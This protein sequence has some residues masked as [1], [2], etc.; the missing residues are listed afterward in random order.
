[1]WSTSKSATILS[2]APRS[3]EIAGIALALAAAVAFAL[4]NTSASVAYHSGSNPLTVAAIRF[5][6]PTAALI[7]W[8][9]M[10]GVRM[11]LQGRD[12]WI[13]AMLGAVTAVYTW[14]LL[15]A[16]GAIPLSLAIL[17]FY[18]FPLIAT[19]ILAACGWERFGWPT[20]AAIVLAFAGLALALD[21]R[22]VRFN[23]EGV[24]LAAGAALGL[25]LVIAVSS[26]VFR[27]GDSRP[28]TLYMAATA[29]MV[30]IVLCAMRGGFVL[31]QTGLGWLGFVGTSVFYAFAMIAFFIAISMIGPVRVSLLS[32]AEPVVA[33]GLSVTLLG[34][35]LAPIQIAGVVLVITALVGATLWRRT[36]ATKG[37]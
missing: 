8:L 31:P 28:V 7:V 5:L 17:V 37:G 15:S 2:S 33:A 11:S 32:Y 14:A 19:I 34:D 4:S 21:P 36:P 1:M 35:K 22:G 3:R 10:R 26:R 27:A 18:L 24:A 13:A 20:V 23:F 16:I 12:G 30:L 9:R 29:A 25:G 6:L